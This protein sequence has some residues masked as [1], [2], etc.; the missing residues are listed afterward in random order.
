[1][2]SCLRKVLRS[3][4]SEVSRSNLRASVTGLPSCVRI[5][6]HSQLVSSFINSANGTR[7]VFGTRFFY[8]CC[9]RVASVFQKCRDLSGRECVLEVPKFIA[10]RWTFIKRARSFR[11][12]LS[13]IEEHRTFCSKINREFVD[14][15][16]IICRGRIVRAQILVASRVR[17][18]VVKCDQRGTTETTDFRMRNVGMQRRV[19]PTDMVGH[20]WIPS[21]NGEC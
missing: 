6:H 9:S 8:R 13:S 17:W 7:S 21:Q 14:V 11:S 12:R 19:S 3:C 15:V 10:S 4:L 18:T 1:M 5:S 2:R 16:V 20:R